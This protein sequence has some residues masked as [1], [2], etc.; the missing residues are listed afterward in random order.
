MLISREQVIGRL[1][2]AGYH[3]S[4]RNKA[5][6]EYVK[7]GDVVYIPRKGDLPDKAVIVVLRQAGL[8]PEEVDR[9]LT[10]CTKN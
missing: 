5:T 1:R 6:E 10:N 4:D 8:T 3:Y 2:E 9:F 7:A